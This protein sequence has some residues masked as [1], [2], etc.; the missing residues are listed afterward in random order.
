MI[1]PLTGV[2]LTADDAD[3]IARA[4]ELLRQQLRANN[5]RPSAKLDMIT[6]RIAK[7]VGNTSAATRNVSASASRS[8]QQPDS[9]DDPVYGWITSP[10]A[11]A[12]LG[13]TANNVRDRARRGTLPAHRAG[14]RWVYP[15]E[16]IVRLADTA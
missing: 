9:D 4:L 12:I 14:G 10:E 5:T 8:L 16:Q 15:A 3:Y 2:F 13:C 7:A 1:E 6:E 11:A